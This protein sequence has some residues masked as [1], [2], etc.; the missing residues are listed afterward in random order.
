MAYYN[1]KG[2]PFRYKGATDVSDCKTA[3]EVMIKAGLNFT[4]DK[5]ELYAKMKIN[6]DA[7]DDSQLDVLIK[8]TKETDSHLHKGDMY[9]NYPNAYCTYRTDYKIP[10]GVVK[11]KYTI[12]QNTEAFNFFDSAIGKNR[13]LF[14]TAGSFGKGETVFVSAKLPFDIMVKDD[15]VDNY[16]VFTNNHDGTAGV[17]ILFTPIRV[18]CKNTLS[19]AIRTTTNYVSFKHTKSVYKNI[20]LAQE[21]LGICK[22]QRDI[23]QTNYDFLAN[24]KVDDDIVM[25]YIVKTIL[26]D[27][28]L[29]QL[30]L[31][32]ISYKSVCYKNVIVLD[33]TTISTRKLNVISE[34]WNY[35]N[36]GV[37]QR[38]IQGTMWGAYNAFSGF[39]SNCDNA[40]GES[41]MNSLLYGDKGRKIQNALEL[42]LT[43]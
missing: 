34:M 38:E 8:E 13:A 21:L 5:C 7:N 25:E 41:R 39:W 32:N 18:I 40:V 31:A 23:I 17:K 26:T 4:V 37:G 3:E 22:K 33:N 10:L 15:P 1:I 20:D 30:K 43:Y 14:Q 42:A 19:A 28:E 16:L 11:Q 24:I 35:Y 6:I 36:E 27:K 29:Q 2:E 9:R 12:V